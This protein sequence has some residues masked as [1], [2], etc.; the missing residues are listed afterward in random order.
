MF[1]FDNEFINIARNV[2]FTNDKR[3]ALKRHINEL[4]GSRLIEE[5]SYSEYTQT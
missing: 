5:K 1:E 2:Y 4:C 3:C